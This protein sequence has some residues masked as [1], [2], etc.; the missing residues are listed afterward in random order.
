MFSIESF[1][2]SFLIEKEQPDLPYKAT[3]SRDKLTA[4]PGFKPGLRASTRASSSQDFEPG[5]LLR[6]YCVRPSLPR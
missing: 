4:K 3:P 5:L 6:R 2:R 1:L